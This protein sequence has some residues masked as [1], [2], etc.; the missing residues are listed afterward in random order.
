MSAVQAYDTSD[1]VD[2]QQIGLCRFFITGIQCSCGCRTQKLN[3]CV[4]V[5]YFNVI[6][7]VNRDV[8]VS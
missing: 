1:V 8:D 7:I 4:D 3:S 2:G 5:L 6:G